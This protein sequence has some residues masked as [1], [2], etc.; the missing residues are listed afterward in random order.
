MIEKDRYDASAALK[1][2]KSFQ[3][4]TVDYVFRRFYEDDN[5]T[6]QFL[7]ADEV[8]L[9]KTMVARG[10]IARAIERLWDRVDR[11]DVLY[12]CSNQ[13]I[14]AQ[15]INRLNVMGRQAFSLPTRMTLLPLQLSGEHGLSR[16]KVNFISLT[17]GTTFDLR[18]STGVM[19]ERA[20]LFHLLRKD[21][22]PPT[23]LRNLLQVHAGPEGWGN[24]VRNISLKG[25][26]KGL[27]ENFRAAV[28][29]NS[30]V[31][32]ELSDLCVQFRRRRKHYPDELANRRNAVIGQ[33]RSILSHICVDALEPDLII[34]DEFQRF[35][36]LLHG[37]HD[38]ATLAQELF[39]YTDRDGNEARTLL[40]S[41]T[42]YRML[43]LSGDDAEEG[44]HYKEFQETLGFLFGRTKGKQI[45]ADLAREMTG[46]RNDLFGLPDSRNQA[47][48]RK[49][50]IEARLREVISRTERVNNTK[51]RDSMVAEPPLKLTVEPDDLREAA[52]VSRVAHVAEAPEIV[53]YWKSAPY[54]LNFMRD[55]ALKRRLKSEDLSRSP[56]LIDAIT[57]ARSSCLNR[58][59]I[60][61]Y[62]PLSPPN[63]RMR[64]LMDDIFESGLDQ[65]L[66]IPPSLPYYGTDETEQTKPTKALVFSSW[67]MVPDAVAGILSYEAER[68]MG[69]KEAGRDY[70]DRTRPRPLQFRVSQG[71][72]AGLRALLL[73]YPSPVLAAEGDPLDIVAANSASLSYEEMRAALAERLRPFLHKLQSSA[74]TDAETDNWEWAGPAVLDEI[75]GYGTSSWLDSHNGFVSLGDE[76]AFPDHV[77]ELRNASV[78]KRVNGTLPDSAL[79]LLVDLALGSPAIC[80]LRALRRV[81]PEL[82]WDDPIMLTEASRIAWGFRT[83]YNQHDSVALLRRASGERYWH[84]V[85]LHAARENLQAVLDEYVHCL[86]ESEGLVDSTPEDR[87][88]GL[89]EK[90]NAVLSLRPSQIEVDDPHVHDGEVRIEQFSLRGRFAMRL[91][92]YRDDEGGA[93]RLSAVRDA[94]NSPFRPFVLASTSIGQEGLDFHPYCHRVYH[95]NLPS[96]PVDLEQREGRVHRYKGHAVR[97]NV[98]R[99]FAGKVRGQGAPSTDPWTSMFAA[100]REDALV[101][102]DMVPYWIY[103]GPTKVERRVPMLPYSRETAR[104]KWLKKSVAVYRLAFGQPRQDD[105]MEYLR[106]MSE[107]LSPEDLEALQIRLAPL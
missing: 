105:L 55:Y 23:G 69:V 53:E 22:E 31:M 100:A 68:R 56:A 71:R 57:E 63:G 95:W 16:N 30:Q 5:T 19:E 96:N 103:D 58:D 43:T 33:L 7:V 99:D 3:H 91:A 78:K 54:L 97:L 104:L 40:L 77:T 9:G 1:P 92:E 39:N 14:A 48:G 49:E 74:D 88:R 17:P 90:I 72:L 6:R 76:E 44:D 93:G 81:A 61:T 84:G 67:S 75:S 64:A 45:A 32:A 18:S 35:N 46:F 34:M 27:I 29:A 25:I 87:V 60:D 24:S 59:E 89:S 52:L 37:D 2:L 10:L 102:N 8:G 51:D 106:T 73:F 26:D 70:F 42:P 11:I 79:E 36:E 82:L 50:G 13:A 101:E 83:L 107:H 38:A 41:A 12:I 98:A 21:V 62:H 28:T 80:A 20:L 85:I 94:F 15:N 66:W 47:F 86:V 65:H 4:R